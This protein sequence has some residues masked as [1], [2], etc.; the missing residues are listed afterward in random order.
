MSIW[1]WG[2]GTCGQL[3]TGVAADSTVPVQATALVTLQQVSCGGNH[4][5]AVSR[6]GMPAFGSC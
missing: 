5:V 4:I 3:G 6:A 2:A 1:S